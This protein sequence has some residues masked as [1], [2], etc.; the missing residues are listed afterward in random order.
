M[1]C[2]ICGAE[3]QDN[4]CVCCGYDRSADRELNPTVM[5]DSLQLTSKLA[6][7]RKRNKS[8]MER[9]DELELRIEK[10]EAIVQGLIKGKLP[11]ETEEQPAVAKPEPEPE[12]LPAVE[13]A[14]IKAGDIISCGRY[15]DTCSTIEWI[16]IEVLQDRY[17]LISKDSVDWCAFDN[18]FAVKTNSWL[19]SSLRRELNGNF[20]NAA[21]SEEEKSRILDSQKE[22]L[23]PRTADNNADKLFLLSESEFRNYYSLIGAHKTRIH[24]SV[25]RMAGQNDNRIWLA[26]QPEDETVGIVA[27]QGKPILI[28]HTWVGYHRGARP[29]MYI[30][31]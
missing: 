16:V 13:T 17:L 7:I 23:N 26:D 20:Y 2:P 22:A 5:K 12:E 25:K 27:R 19:K 18:A 9:C 15:P 11:V 6:L 3:A 31:R 1:I 24:P 21:F 4:M 30:K 10:L 28:E 14:A 29:C 8:A